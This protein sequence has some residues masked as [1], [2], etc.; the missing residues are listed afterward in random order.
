MNK[1]NMSIRVRGNR[2]Q[3]LVAVWML[4]IMVSGAAGAQPLS[5]DPEAKAPTLI[6]FKAEPELGEFVGRAEGT[7]DADGKQLYLKGLNVLA[8]LVIQVFAKDP[9]K[10]VD[11]ALHR[12]IWQKANLEGKTNENGNWGY[13]GRIH[14]EVGIALSA[15]E[16]AEYYVLAWMGPEIDTAPRANL[17]A[18]ASTGSAGPTTSTNTPAAGIPTWALI[19]IIALLAII[20]VLLLRNRK[21]GGSAAALLVGVSLLTS[22]SHDAHASDPFAARLANVE[23][24]LS[25]VYSDIE[26]L[27]RQRWEIDRELDNVGSEIDRIRA[28]IQSLSDWNEFVNNRMNGF[29]DRMFRTEE[30]AARKFAAIDTAL[31]AQQFINETL[32]AHINQLYLLVEEDRVAEP[33]RSY[34]GVEPMPSNCF[35]NPACAACFDS[36]NERLQEQLDLYEQLRSI[37]ATNQS[38]TEYAVMTGDALSGFH[39][40]E[41]AEWYRQKLRIKE[42]QMG[43][44]RAYNAKFDEFNLKLQGI[45]Q[46]IGAC[47][48]R[49]GT[50]DWYQRYGTLFYNSLINAYRN[51]DDTTAPF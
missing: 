32:T 13:T 47:E 14:D 15:D 23:S 30:A 17:F 21:S 16:P 24:N 40:L 51:F 8:P 39:Q 26:Y 7:V 36:A 9:E 20:A 45:L 22:Y 3:S 2:M 42:A 37:Y 25:G 31:A 10:P 29:E 50:D 11:V 1:K 41:Q 35:D 44:T 19:A 38:F 49:H 34:G 6:E 4:A 5:L 48:A 33:D 43:V 28:R 46:D 27:M 18:P 12:F